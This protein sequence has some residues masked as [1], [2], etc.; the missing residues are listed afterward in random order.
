MALS[1]KHVLLFVPNVIGYIRLV[2]MLAAAYLHN[3]D[4]HTDVVIA[5]CAYLFR[6]LVSSIALFPCRLRSVV[7]VRVCVCGCV[8]AQWWRLSATC[9][10]A[11]R[12]ENSTNAQSLEKCWTLWLTSPSNAVLISLFSSLPCVHRVCV[13]VSLCPSFCVVEPALPTVQLLQVLAVVFCSSGVSQVGPA[14]L[15][16]RDV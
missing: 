14:V 6:W 13:C 3:Q 16:D 12:H 10:T 11:G 9:W 5:Y 2:I 15:R 8:C 7:D 4:R 1:H